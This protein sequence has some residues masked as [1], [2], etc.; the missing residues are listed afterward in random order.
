[1]QEMSDPLLHEGQARADARGHVLRGARMLLR[2]PVLAIRHLLDGEE[3]GAAPAGLQAGS[4]LICAE[5]MIS[6]HPL[7]LMAAGH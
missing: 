1:V 4:S 6:M 5:S 7:T 3:G 2:H